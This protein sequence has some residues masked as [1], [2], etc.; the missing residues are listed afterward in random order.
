L[1]SY[2]WYSSKQQK[3]RRKLFMDRIGCDF[4]EL[5][6]ELFYEK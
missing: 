2:C 6:L 5:G 1:P 4:M 3:L